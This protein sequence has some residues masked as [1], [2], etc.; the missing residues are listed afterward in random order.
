MRMFYVLQLCSAL[1][2]VHEKGILH[3][4]LKPQNLLLA[5]NRKD[6]LLLADFSGT[7]DEQSI[8]AGGK[9]TGVFSKFWADSNARAGKYSKE[10]EVYAFGLCAHYLIWGQPLFDE[11]NE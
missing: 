1:K 10:S 6:K 8:H 5:S 2:K 3:R 7:K 4:D 9:Q 11:D